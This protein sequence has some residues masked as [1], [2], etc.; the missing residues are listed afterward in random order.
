VASV[1]KGRFLGYLVPSVTAGAVLDF[2]EENAELF[3]LPI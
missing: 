2:L 3:D 1:G